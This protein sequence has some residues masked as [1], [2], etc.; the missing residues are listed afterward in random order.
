LRPLLAPGGGE[1]YRDPIRQKRLSYQFGYDPGLAV[2]CWKMIFLG[3]LDQAAR[4]SEQVRAAGRVSHLGLVAVGVAGVPLRIDSALV[5][6]MKS[7]NQL[8]EFCL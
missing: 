6:P 8:I 5:I 1:R 3:L 4:L 7:A 2:L